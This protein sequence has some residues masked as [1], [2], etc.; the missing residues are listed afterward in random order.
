VLAPGGNLAKSSDYLEVE[1]HLSAVG[2]RIEVYTEASD[3]G[4]VASKTLVDLVETFDSLVFPSLVRRFG[5]AIDVDRNGRFTVFLT[6]RLGKAA[7]GPGVDGFVRSADLDRGVPAPF[8]NNC[9]MMY[10]N[11]SL[12]SGSYLRTILAHEYTHAIGFSR[13]V[14]G[15][16]GGFE[17]EGWLDEAIA[18]LVED[19]F[20]FSRSNIDYRV[21]AFLSRPERYRLVV[22][23]YYAAELFRE[24]GNRGATYLFLR[25]CVDQFGPTLLE[26]LVLS[27]YRGV[28]NLEAATGWAFD[29]LFRNWTIALA[30]SGID[31]HSEPEGAYRSIDPRGEFEDWIL[32]GPRTST[33]STRSRAD[34]WNAEPTTAHYCVVE[35]SS[36]GAV[37]VEVIG[38]PGAALQVTIVP[39]PVGSGRPELIVRGTDSKSGMVHVQAEVIERGGRPIRLGSLAWEPL[40]PPI[41]PRSSATTRGALDMLGIAARFGTS[42]LPASG[43]LR[44]REIP[45][46]RVERGDGPLVFKVVGLDVAGRR[47]AAWA[48]F[49]PP[50]AP[51][52]DSVVD[53]SD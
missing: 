50:S 44:C 38:P 51:V 18:H 32:A 27:P 10:L 40:V 4:V 47:V 28:R 2:R 14:L 16:G 45:L 48:E 49:T 36:P 53:G 29:D 42:A 26:R 37:G 15:G 25:W 21:S 13:K 19:D 1:A 39:L 34:S 35:N 12:E 7:G 20:G 8:G 24:H 22:E 52:R 6:S 3:V 43:S 23:D 9:D 11:T 5:P 41:A 17:E 31:G 33:V 46:P 30:I